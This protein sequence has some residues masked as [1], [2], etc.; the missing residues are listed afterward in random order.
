MKKYYIYDMETGKYLGSV[1]ASS[2]ESAELS[3][4]SA[5]IKLDVMKYM[6]YQL[7]LMNHGHNNNSGCDHYKQGFKSQAFR[8]CCRR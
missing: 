7:H 2:I 1:F 8:H 3:N 6:L 5:K 4:I